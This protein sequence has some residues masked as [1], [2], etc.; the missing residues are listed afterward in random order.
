MGSDRTTP[1][2][3]LSPVAFNVLVPARFMITVGHLLA[4]IMVSYTQVGP[5]SVG[6]H[7][8]RSPSAVAWQ[9]DNIQASLS[10]N[11]TN[12][13]IIDA[14]SRMEVPKQ[15][16]LCTNTVTPRHC[17]QGYWQA[18]LCCFFFDFLGMFGG[19]SLFFKSV[20]Q[21]ASLRWPLQ[22]LT[23]LPAGEFPPGTYAIAERWAQSET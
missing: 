17:L 4:T 21:T 19:F 15:L 10:L 23:M 9:E 3:Y 12:T 14:R 5:A 18:A 8:G 7:G 20:S 16:F 13:E 22:R 1:R 11:P 2:Q 6:R